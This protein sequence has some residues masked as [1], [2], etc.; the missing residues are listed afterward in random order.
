LDSL[1]TVQGIRRFLAR[2]VRTPL[3]VLAPDNREDKN[4][5]LIRSYTLNET[6]AHTSR[7]IEKHCPLKAIGLDMKLS[8]ADPEVSALQS[9]AEAITALGEGPIPSDSMPL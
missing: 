6:E 9:L 1:L 2:I 3:P 4:G 7:R 8:G 5:D